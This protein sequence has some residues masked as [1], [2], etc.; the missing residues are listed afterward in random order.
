MCPFRRLRLLYLN[1]VAKIS[2]CATGHLSVSGGLLPCVSG[3][4]DGRTQKARNLLKRLNILAPKCGANRHGK[5]APAA[6][7]GREPGRAFNPL[8][9]F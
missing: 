9:G 7:Q 3:C 4:R 1:R 5:E 2:A 8:P 6:G